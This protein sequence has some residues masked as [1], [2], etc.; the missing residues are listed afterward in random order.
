MGMSNDLEIAIECGANVVRVGSA[1]VG[2][3]TVEEAEEE[4]VDD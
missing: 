1:L 2:E 3:P 4:I